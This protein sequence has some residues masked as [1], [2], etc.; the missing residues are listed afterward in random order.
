M[1]APSTIFRHREG[2]HSFEKTIK[3]LK[4]LSMGGYMR[5][6]GIIGVILAV[7]CLRATA[8]KPDTT[9]LC[10]DTTPEV[11]F[12][13]MY[14]SDTFPDNR[15]MFSMVDTGDKIDGNYINFDYKFSLD[16]VYLKAANSDTIYPCAPRPGYAGFKIFWDYGV[17]SFYVDARDSMVFWHKGPLP[18]HKVKMIWAQGSAG[19][20]TP[21]NYQYFGEYKSSDT[22][23]RESFS[24]PE[25]RNYGSAPDSAFV[26][27][28]LFELRMQI[29]NDSS[30]GT[31]SDTSPQGNL[32]IDN[33]FFLK[34]AAGVRNAKRAPVAVGGPTSFIPTV[35]GM[36][37][38]AIYSL[39]GDLLFKEPVDVTA[40][41]RYDVSKFARKN[42]NLPARRIHCVQIT[43]SGVNLTR[44][45]LR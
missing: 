41:K 22:W 17:G 21:I 32:K 1:S 33:M 25:K 3:S 39:Q 44:K 40:G 19:C 8:Q 16:S 26:T 30:T 14:T 28:G 7:G 6:H 42:S 13:K 11:M 43:G 34:S 9:W 29:Y 20:G 18:G 35:S 15:G 45:V 24:F 38:L 37:T 4:L 31:V 12:V 36:V 10:R 5:L 2:E 23:E 27:R